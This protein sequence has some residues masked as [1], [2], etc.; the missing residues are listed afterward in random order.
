MGF[1]T[2]ID[3]LDQYDG[4]AL[5]VGL[6]KVRLSKDI[7]RGKRLFFPSVTEKVFD[8]IK[9]MNHALLVDGVVIVIAREGYSAK[10]KLIDKIQS[11]LV[12][13]Y[14]KYVSHPSKNETIP[15]LLGVRR[16]KNN[17]MIVREMT[18]AANFPFHV[19]APLCDKI[20]KEKLGLPVVIL[21]PGPS[22]KNV[23]PYLTELKKR[24]V[25]VCVTR[26]LPILRECGV[27]PDFALLL[28]TA[29]RMTHFTPVD[30]SW[31]DTYLISLSVANVSSIAKNFRGL[32]FF[33]SFDL[34]YLGNP[35]RLRESWLSCTLSTLGLA[36]A[37]HAPDVYLAGLDSC[38]YD[39][40]LAD[41]TPAN[42]DISPVYSTLRNEND[43]V[44]IPDYSESEPILA[45][46]STT[47]PFH[48]RD[49]LGRT[50]TTFFS[51]YATAYELGVF[52]EDITAKIGTAFHLL[53]KMGILDPDIFNLNGANHLNEKY[54]LIDRGRM[55][56]KLDEILSV[57]EDIDFQSYIDRTYELLK[58]VDSETANIGHCL[59]NG[60]LSNIRKSFIFESL[61]RAGDSGKFNVFDKH[62][63]EVAAHRSGQ[64]WGSLL[65][66]SIAISKL[67]KDLEHGKPINV[68]CLPDELYEV[69]SKAESLF[70]KYFSGLEVKLVSFYVP[71]A[72]PENQNNYTVSSFHTGQET[73]FAANRLHY[74]ITFAVS[75][76]EDSSCPIVSNR[77][78]EEF[79]YILDL[80]PE[81]DFLV[82]DE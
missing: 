1:V 62:Q 56:Y 80:L 64:K 78:F 76:L 72:F 4:K 32:F 74:Y 43:V 34:N 13:L 25:L 33:E 22:L 16:Q 73:Y 68:F 81:D 63:C 18:K 29:C 82:L 45:N 27:A 61:K 5:V 6:G 31:K 70:T 12:Y 26:V 39:L 23:L 37:L 46:E 15:D 14:A 66:K 41:Q 7:P 71:H 58:V 19:R 69:R 3:T 53:E 49:V 36:E 79:R 52:A 35:Y 2:V 11:H 75:R 40:D 50:A 54:P 57:R 30:Q 65:R 60:E 17:F 20:A 21:G 10:R 44:S 48:T 38:W 28:D 59:A 67:F 42:T 55:Q 47:K 8:A 77:L 24:A 9:V 51:Y